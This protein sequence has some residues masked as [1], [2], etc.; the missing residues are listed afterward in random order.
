MP[1]DS[2][3]LLLVSAER[4]HLLLRVADVEELE[5]VVARRRQQPVAILK[6]DTQNHIG[7]SL[8][9]DVCLSL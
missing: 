1:G 9:L 8:S 2:R 3:G 4:L 5:E 6:Q 7:L